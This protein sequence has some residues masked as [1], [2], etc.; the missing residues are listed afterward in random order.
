[1][2]RLESIKER[3]EKGHYIVVHESAHGTPYHDNGPEEDVEYLL[4]RLEIAQKAL[5][6]I[7]ALPNHMSGAVARKA[8]DQLKE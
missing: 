1:M 6:N 2:S 7:I 3:L 5:D 4:Q 8:L